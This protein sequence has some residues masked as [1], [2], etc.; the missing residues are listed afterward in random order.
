[1]PRVGSEMLNSLL[2][3][4]SAFVTLVSAI[5]DES[6]IVFSNNLINVLPKCDFKFPCGG[7]HCKKKKKLSLCQV[8]HC[9]TRAESGYLRC[10]CLGLDWRGG[11]EIWNLCWVGKEHSLVKKGMQKGEEQMKSM[12]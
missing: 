8:F 12:G 9:V 11:L 3:I 6:C 4:I 1:M 5:L 10:G 2:H 7:V